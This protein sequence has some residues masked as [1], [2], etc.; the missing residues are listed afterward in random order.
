MFEI[1]SI[2]KFD[3]NFFF[4]LE[5]NFVIFYLWSLENNGL[6]QG[7]RIILNHAEMCYG[8]DSYN[9]E[10]DIEKKFY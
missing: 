9:L 2:S 6:V 4:I 10:G 7:F 1:S 3:G 5:P 8:W